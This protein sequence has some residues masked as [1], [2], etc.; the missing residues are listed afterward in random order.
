MRKWIIQ[1]ETVSPAWVRAIITTTGMSESTL[2]RLAK[3]VMVSISRRL[4]TSDVPANLRWKWLLF[5]SSI[6]SRVFSRSV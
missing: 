6:A 3:L 1:L 4:P 5:C 2:L